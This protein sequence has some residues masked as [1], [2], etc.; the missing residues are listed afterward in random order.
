MCVCVLLYRTLL[1]AAAY[2]KC[3]C[4]YY[5]ADNFVDNCKTLR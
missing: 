2:G 5:N 4:D 3:F 1:K